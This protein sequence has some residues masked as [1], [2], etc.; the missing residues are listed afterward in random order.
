VPALKKTRKPKRNINKPQKTVQKRADKMQK[1]KKRNSNFLIATADCE[2]NPFNYGDTI[3]PFVWGFYSEEEGSNHWW[4]DDPKIC[5]LQFIDFL[6]SLKEPHIIYLHNGGKFD[7]FFFL[8]YITGEVRIV[9]GRVLEC[10]IGPHIIR[11]SYAAIPIA[12]A[13]YK[14]DD[15]NYDLLKPGIRNKNKSKIIKYLNNDCIYLYEM[16]TRFLDE[17][18]NRLTIGGAAMEQLKT[19]H[20]FESGNQEFDKLFRPFYSGGRNQCFKTGIINQPIKIFDKNSMYPA[21]MLNNLHPIGCEYITSDVF[22]N[23][24]DFAVIEAINHGALAARVK[25]GLDFTVPRGT[26]FATGHEIRAGLETGTLEILSVKTAYEFRRRSTFREFVLHFYNLRMH[27]KDISDDLLLIFYKLILNSA[28][29]KFCTDCEDYKDWF[30]TAADEM[31]ADPWN[32]EIMHDEYILWSKPSLQKKY[33][34]VATGASITGA[35]RAELLYGLAAAVDPVYCDT[36]SIMCRD[37][38]AEIDSKKLGAWKFE[39]E[40]D[41]LAIG[42]KK[43]YALYKDGAPVM[44]KG[45]HDTLIEYKASKGVRLTS[46]QILSIARGDVIKYENPVPAFKLDGGQIYTHRH[47]RTTGSGVIPFGK[48]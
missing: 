39:A 22:D 27:A 25:N 45:P 9:N 11:D 32:P 37:L 6:Y 4:N 20:E 17:F 15:M 38:H 23:N 2:T 3:A 8:E 40:G 18:G 35:S 10:R 44:K 24:T 7:I 26:F 5:T 43:L 12:L 31:L 29:G 33:F 47:I 19:F 13:V 21:V 42:G 1:P 41:M 16:I 34:N 48:Q 46:A 36:D 28:Y 30:I 14:K